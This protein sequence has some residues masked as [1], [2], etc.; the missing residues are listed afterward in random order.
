LNDP[1]QRRRLYLVAGAGAVLLLALLFIATANGS[2]DSGGG[3]VVRPAVET[4]APGATE[5]SDSTPGFSLG[6]GD[7]LSLAWR[8]GLVIVII[9]AAV[10]GLRW[11]GKRT[12][13][14]RSSTGYLRIVDTMAISNG[15]T[16]HLVALG[17]RVI[18]IG[19]TAQQLSLLTELGPEESSEVLAESEGRESASLTGFAAEL[20]Q[21][22]RRNARHEEPAELTVI[23]EKS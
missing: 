18:A 7:L 12:A 1:R 16:I 10:A 21:S 2:G 19:A 15:R 3:P 17:K 4:S 20:L 23:G 11:W 8:L 13:G 5:A 14:P 6:G 22:V 9:A